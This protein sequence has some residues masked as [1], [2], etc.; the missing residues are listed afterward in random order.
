MQNKIFK[1]YYSFCFAKIEQMQQ[2][3]FTPDDESQ[4]QEIINYQ[5]QDQDVFQIID[6]AQQQITLQ[7]SDDIFQILLAKQLLGKPSTDQELQQLNDVQ[8]TILECVQKKPTTKRVEEKQKYVFKKAFKHIEQGFR[9]KHGQKKIRKDKQKNVEEFYQFHFQQVSAIQKIPLQNFFHPQKLIKQLRPTFK[10]FN[11]TY[12][13]LIMSSSSFRREVNH[14]LQNKFVVEC[15]K[16]RI[17]KLQKFV[18]CC[19]QA[20]Y[21]AEQ[22]FIYYYAK[23]DQDE[24]FGREY[25]RKKLEEYIL[26]NPK[27][28]IPW[29][30]Q[31]IY[32][33]RDFAL[34]HIEEE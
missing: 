5:D 19:Y 7:G 6:D 3:F 29:S 28:K 32:D 8:K 10:S 16:E 30:N 22:D 33:A 15:E 27:C 17:K 26:L 14:Y 25:I 21:Q 9:K 24:D 11:Q 18:S 2:E 4:K 31:E 23:D 13:K 34:G 20:Y 12:I 1:A